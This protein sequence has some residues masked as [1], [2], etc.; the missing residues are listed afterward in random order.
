MSLDTF[1]VLYEFNKNIHHSV[2][3][4]EALNRHDAFDKDRID[5]LSADLEKSKIAVN[6]ACQ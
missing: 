3:C 4:L 2:L 1:E 5:A 6:G